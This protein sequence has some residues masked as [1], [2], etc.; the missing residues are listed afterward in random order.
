[1]VEIRNEKE[2]QGWIDGRSLG[3]KMSI[4]F[5]ALGRVLPILGSEIENIKFYHDWKNSLCASAFSALLL[6]AARWKS[7]G[8]LKFNEKNEF[9]TRFIGTSLSKLISYHDD[10][11]HLMRGFKCAVEGFHFLIDDD[12]AKVDAFYTFLCLE[13]RVGVDVDDAWRAVSLDATALESGVDLWS[14]PLWL[15]DIPQWAA[16]GWENLATELTKRTPYWKT[17]VRWYEDR[18]RGDEWAASQG[19]PA[20]RELEIARASLPD[21]YW[22]RGGKAV[23]LAI[24]ELEDFFWNNVPLKDPALRELVNGIG[25]ITDNEDVAP[26]AEAEILPPIPDLPPPDLPAQSHGAHFGIRDGLIA[27]APPDH[28]DPARN[29][30]QRL[31]SLHPLL[32]AETQSAISIFGRNQAHGRIHDALLRY[33]H[34]LDGDVTALDF[35]VLC[36]LGGKLQAEEAAAKET[37]EDGL[38]PPFERSEIAALKALLDLHGPFVL[39]TEIGQ[40]FVADA[41]RWQRNPQEEA[42][43]RQ[44]ATDFAE[45]VEADGIATPETAAFVKDAAASAGTGPQPERSAMFGIGTVRNVVI[46]TVGGAA[47]YAAG[48]AI[49]SWDLTHWASVIL[50]GEMIKK[51]DVGMAISGA[52]TDLINDVTRGKAMRRVFD[53]ALKNEPSLRALAGNRREFSFLNDWLDWLKSRQEPK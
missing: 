1:M 8:S 3:W 32:L 29:N 6:L 39:A 44:T 20:I 24:A 30:I 45:A 38:E 47:I 13:Y 18:L 22:K 28:L 40:Q 2:L 43:F 21:S 5:R 53:F 48:S 33:A 50:M 51:S 15:D 9:T 17:L 36:G 23:N 19:R 37:I 14:Q 26:E 4:S 16:E 31:K 34:W 25:V 49:A 42:A 10:L 52:G 27:F 11:S 12:D 46:V 41:E 7:V 35:D